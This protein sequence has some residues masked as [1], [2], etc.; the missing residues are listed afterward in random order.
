MSDL[1]F[2]I[3]DEPKRKKPEVKK[4]K[5]TTPRKPR[6]ASTSQPSRSS[7][8][9]VSKKKRPFKKARSPRST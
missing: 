9:Q 5:R 7:G 2:E 3:D 8:R 6:A 4:G 1:L